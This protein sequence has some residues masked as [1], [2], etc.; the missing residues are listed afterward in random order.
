MNF[1]GGSA[2]TLDAVYNNPEF[3]GGLL[4]LLRVPKASVINE[5]ED[6][7][8]RALN[9]AEAE[10]APASNTPRT[11]SPDFPQESSGCCRGVP[12]SPGN[13]LH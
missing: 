3:G 8:A 6:I 5:G 7:G 4:C 9:T 12:E 13:S 2:L 10:R 1:V 11:F